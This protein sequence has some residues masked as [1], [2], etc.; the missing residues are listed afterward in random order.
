M[1]TGNRKLVLFSH[2]ALDKVKYIKYN[3]DIIKS[4]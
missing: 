1:P 4:N 2:K 3:Q